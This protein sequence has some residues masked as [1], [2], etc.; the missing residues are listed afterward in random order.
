MKR[1]FG[2][3]AEKL[4]EDKRITRDVRK[5]WKQKKDEEA[6]MKAKP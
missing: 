1:E 5:K 6:A 3:R 4:G 2:D